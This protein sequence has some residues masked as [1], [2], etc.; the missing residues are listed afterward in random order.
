MRLEREVNFT[1][2]G[3]TRFTTRNSLKSETQR[4]TEVTQESHLFWLIDV[5][6]VLKFKI[7]ESQ[8][9]IQ[10]RTEWSQG[11]THLENDIDL[12]RQ[13]LIYKLKNPPKGETELG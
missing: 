3:I 8:K 1:T 10:R 12:M 13:E 7:K 4:Q 11:M 5:V 6:E 9:V 2:V